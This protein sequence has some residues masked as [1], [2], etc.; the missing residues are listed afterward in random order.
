MKADTI[1]INFDKCPLR[2]AMALQKFQD[3]ME[4]IPV[5]ALEEL[6]EKYTIF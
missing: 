4:H 1:T 6:N 3:N 2:E 5:E